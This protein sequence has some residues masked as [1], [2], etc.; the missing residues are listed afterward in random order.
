MTSEEMYYEKRDRKIQ[1][2][3]EKDDWEN[4]LSGFER[5]ESPD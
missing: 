4:F 2:Q 3:R 1:E 5:G